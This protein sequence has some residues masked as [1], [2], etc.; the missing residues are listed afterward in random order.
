MTEENKLL[1]TQQVAIL[2]GISDGRLRVLIGEGRA[3]P[4]EQIG[5]TWL[6]APDEVERLRN[7]PRP[8]GKRKK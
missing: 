8:R 7:T 6:F 3:I 1:T 2:L 5:G 4:K